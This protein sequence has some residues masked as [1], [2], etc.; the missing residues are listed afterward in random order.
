MHQHAHAAEGAHVHAHDH[1]HDVARAPAEA[2]LSLL[3][4]SAA[5]R[6]ISALGLLALLWLGVF[7]AMR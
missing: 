2:G 1:D 5:V 4:L 6:A 3:R 7:W